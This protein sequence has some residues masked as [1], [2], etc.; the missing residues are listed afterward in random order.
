MLQKY[1]LP[2]GLRVI[3]LPTHKA[4]V[5]TAHA[6]VRTGSADEL[7]GEEG[8]SHFIEHLLFK[9]TRKFKVGEIASL[10]EGCGG[11]LNA[12]TSFDQTVFHITLSKHFS[13]RAIECL[14]DMMGFPAFDETETDNEREVVIEEIKR[15]NDSPQRAGS[16]LLFETVYQRHPYRIPVI[17]YDENIR[18]FTPKQIQK[19]YRG[20]YSPKNMS[21]LVVGDFQAPDMKALVKKYFGEIPATPVRKSKRSSE[22]NQTSPRVS[23]RT[24]NFEE[25]ILHVAFPI[26]NAKHADIPALD[27][28]ALILGQGESSRLY[29][30]LRLRENTVTYVGSHAYTPLDSGFFSV[31]AGLHHSKMSDVLDSIGEELLLIQQVPPSETELQKAIRI[32]EADEVFGAET[33]DGLARKIGTFEQI[34]AK[35][36]YYEKYLRQLSEV[37]ADDVTRV[38]RKYFTSKNLNVCVMAQKGASDL[39]KI[40]QK[41]ADDYKSAHAVFSKLA[42]EKLRTKPQKLKIPKIKSGGA[43]SPIEFEVEGVRVVAYPDHQS[44]TVALRLGMIGGQRLEEPEQ[45]GL[46]ELTS[47]VWLSGTK[48]RSEQEIVEWLDG[49]AVGLRAFAGRNTIGLSLNCLSQDLHDAL[50]LTGEVLKESTFP[51]DVVER[52]KAQQLEAIRQKSDNPSQIAVEAFQKMMFGSHPYGRPTAGSEQTVP[53]LSGEQ[54]KTYLSKLLMR[55][56]LSVAVSGDFQP[57]VLK[58]NLREMFQGIPN[59]ESLLKAQ[60]VQLPKAPT[61][62][63]IILRKEQAHV[64]C[65]FPAL[66]LADPRT[67]TLQ[68]INSILSGQGGRLFLEL[69]DKASLAYSVSPIG[70]EGI[71]AGFFGA[72]IGCSPDKVEKAINMMMVEFEKLKT[73]LVPEAELE[74]AKR[75]VLGRHDIGLQ[76]NSSVASSLFFSAIYNQSTDQVFHLDRFLSAIT[77]KEIR[78]LARQVFDGPRVIQIVG[79]D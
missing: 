55:K 75:Y 29:Q 3:L 31:S 54:M 35:P 32:L 28:L 13:E 79:P 44:P 59:G 45:A 20:R 76:R 49:R 16:R 7:R 73:D 5:V 24:S 61:Q 52:E 33:V 78:E 26:P 34:F 56:N 74:R 21:L 27:I 70:M 14:S 37:T 71:E 38:A 57:E 9:G 6:W 40:A 23:V 64:V 69:R 48:S 8:I 51:E 2:N 62:D 41:F 66:T 50:K 60:S 46:A 67:H 43:H 17:G 68:L 63:R 36:D 10:V 58:Q 22:A 72:Y 25:S 65:G 18:G 12:Y 42:P 77:S 39:Q 19:Y 53:R 15:S 30:R 1:Q 11:E 4:P 47:N